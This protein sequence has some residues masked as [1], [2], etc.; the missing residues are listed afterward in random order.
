MRRLKWIKLQLDM[1]N[2][3]RIQSIR[4]LRKGS[5]YVLLLLQLKLLAASIDDQGYIYLTKEMPSTVDVIAG[6]FSTTKRSWQRP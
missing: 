1:F 4:K 5:E 2:D 6:C 3:L